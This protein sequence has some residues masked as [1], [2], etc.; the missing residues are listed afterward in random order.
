MKVLG[1]LLDSWKPFIQQLI[2]KTRTNIF[3]LRY[4][5][6]NLLVKVV[7]SQV[8]SRLGYGSPVWSAS[9]RYALRA[10]IRSV[11]F[12][13]IRVIIRD[14][15][16]RFSRSRMLRISGLENT[17]DIFFKRTSVF[18]YNVNYYLKPTTLGGIILSKPYFIMKDTKKNWPSLTQAKQKWER[19]ASQTLLIVTVTIGSL[20]G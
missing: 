12:L 16:L 6:R 13:A 1:V 14:F 5:R 15:N 7:R 9:L 20:T 8:I 19:N 17:E 3:A 18:L 10:R 11:Y 2:G 4:I